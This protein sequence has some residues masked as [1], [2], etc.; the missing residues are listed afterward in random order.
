MLRLATYKSR[1]V[2][3][4]SSGGVGVSIDIK[5]GKTGS[6]YIG[7]RKVVKH[8]DSGVNLIGFKIHEWKKI[9]KISIDAVSELD[10]EYAGVDIALTEKGIKVIEVNIRPGLEIQKITKKG[11]WKMI[12]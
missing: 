11:L 10:L 9:L 3:N 12:R 4:I 8:P 1:G 5:S 6:A 7:N 2:A